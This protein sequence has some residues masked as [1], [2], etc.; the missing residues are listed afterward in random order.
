M[1]EI[2]LTLEKDNA[3]KKFIVMQNVQSNETEIIFKAD[4][5]GKEIV[6]EICNELEYECEENKSQ[7]EGVYIIKLKKSIEIK[8]SVSDIIDILIPLSP[9][10]VNQKLLNPTI[11][12]LF[13]PQ[14]K[15]VTILREGVYNL[16]IKWIISW[17]TPLS[18][19]NVKIDELRYIVRYFASQKT[20]LFSVFFGFDFYITSEGSG[21]R[22]KMKEWYK[23]PFKSLAKGEIEKHL[24][25]AKEVMPEFIV[26]I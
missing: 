9:K 21:S 13:I 14:I 1:K 24:K 23:G 10:D 22:I 26:R 6:K 8:G 25:K 11:L 16:R 17:D 15:A 4:V 20:P 2:D 19:Y 7:E 12:T 5:D 18:V 3:I